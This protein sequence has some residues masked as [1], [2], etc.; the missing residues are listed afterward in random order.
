ME[1]N[2]GGPLP[3]AVLYRMPPGYMGGCDVI[4]REKQDAAQQEIFRRR[5]G[6]ELRR[7]REAS[8]ISQDLAADVN[9]WNRDAM[10]KIERGERPIGMFE[11]LRLM[12]FYQELEPD[13]PAVALAARLLPRH[14][15]K[16]Q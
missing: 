6:Q 3:N 15:G 9:G 12:W 11:Y 5:L 2:G 1:A 14:S 10:S 8:G 16:P 13:H 4:P 7:F